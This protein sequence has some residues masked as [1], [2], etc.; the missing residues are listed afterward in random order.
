MAYTVC[1]NLSLCGN[2]WYNLRE[3]AKCPTTVWN[4]H[5][6]GITYNSYKFTSADFSFCRFK[7]C[8]FN[9]CV[10]EDSVGYKSRFINCTFNDC[11]FQNFL[12][13]K[14]SFENVTFFTCFAFKNGKLFKML[15]TVK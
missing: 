2:F 12:L 14:P 6:E 13:L 9:S 5:L 10:F 15:H 4:T 1:G 8:T 3:I 11:A 7:N